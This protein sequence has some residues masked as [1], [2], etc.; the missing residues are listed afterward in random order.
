MKRRLSAAA[1]EQDE[2][3]TTEICDYLEDLVCHR[4][5]YYPRDMKRITDPLGAKAGWP[6]RGLRSRSDQP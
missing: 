1:G 5:Q 4:G 2:R 3:A 6:R